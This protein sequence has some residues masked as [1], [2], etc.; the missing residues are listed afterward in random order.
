MEPIEGRAKELLEAPNFANVS[1]LRKDGS[2]HGAVVW[3]HTEDGNL[4]VNS[5]E[6][7][8]WPAMVRRDPRV[9]LTVYDKE[10]P[11]EYV[12]VRGRVV[13]ERKGEEA[14][15]NINA[16]AKKYLDKDEYPFR[17][18]GEERV[19]FLIAPERVRVSSG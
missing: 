3:V 2:V 8:A 12:E 7:R 17:Q 13:E 9:T 16:L 19:K 5:A 4:V 18:P 10:N 14:D 1:T 11:Y 15:T 6:G